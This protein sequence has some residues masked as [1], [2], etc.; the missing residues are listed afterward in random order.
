MKD[1]MQNKT[2]KSTGPNSLPN[3]ITKQA[4]DV[5]YSPLT[6]VINKSFSKRI[7][8]SALKISK[9]VPVFKS[10][11][12]LPCN[13][14]RPISFLSNVSKIIEK[15][16]CK[17]LSKFLEQPRHFYN[18]QFGSRVNCSTNNA[19]MAIIENIRTH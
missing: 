1:I 9:V 8:P 15:L 4:K 18:L 6:E 16:M 10:E 11:S 19:H 14:C 13:N 7:F 3:K 17:R 12:R 2:N 5:I